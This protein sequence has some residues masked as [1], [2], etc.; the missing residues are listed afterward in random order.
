MISSPSPLLLIIVL[1]IVMT[2]ALFFF[3][4]GAPTPTGQHMMDGIKGLRQYLNLAEKERMNLAGVPEMSPQHYEKLLPYAVAL[5]VEKPWSKAFDAWL[6]AAVAAGAVAASY[7]P[8][9]YR[10]RDFNS[11]SVGDS[12]RDI[13]NGMQSSFSSAMPVPQSSSS[14]FSGGGSSGG[15]GGGGGGGGW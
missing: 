15:G 13:S 11:G 3:L 9:W 1:G 2:N 10:G 7:S 6:A 4:M 12:M 14:G 5:G 8:G